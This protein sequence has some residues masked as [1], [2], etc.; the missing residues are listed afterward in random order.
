MQSNTYWTTRIPKPSRSCL[1]LQKSLYDSGKNVSVPSKGYIR[2]AWHIDD[3]ERQHGVDHGSS[4]EMSIV[5]PS[6]RDTSLQ[7]RLLRFLKHG[8]TV[9]FTVETAQDTMNE[10]R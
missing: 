9:R 6:P 8:V 5:E 10:V 4:E 1:Q 3:L 7:P 2:S